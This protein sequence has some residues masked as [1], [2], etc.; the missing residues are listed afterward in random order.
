MN[1]KKIFELALTVSMTAAIGICAAAESEVEPA[2]TS[3]DKSATEY[4]VEIPEH[5]LKRY[6]KINMDAAD[7]NRVFSC[8][9]D[10]IYEYFEEY[11][12]NPDEFTWP[13][14]KRDGL[15]EVD[16]DNSWMY[17]NIIWVNYN[18]TEELYCTD[19]YEY[20]LPSEEHMEL[21]HAVLDGIASWAE[22][23]QEEEVPIG[24]LMWGLEDMIFPLG[25]KLPEII[26][27]SHK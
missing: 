7:V 21:M 27:F 23:Y 22:E 5:A 6:E 24:I 15:T 25:E 9:E 13:E 2:D 10:S 3:A 26:V 20:P 8:I 1:R 4:T 11:E 17:L 14:Y 18:A 12:I 19:G 16:E